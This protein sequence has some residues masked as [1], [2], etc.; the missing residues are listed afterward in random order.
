MNEWRILVVED[1]IDG[2]EVVAELLSY[3]NI[4]SDAVMTGEEA[5]KLLKSRTYNGVAIDLALPGMDGWEVLQ[6]IRSN[7]ET[8]G[9]PC[10]AMTA[11]HTS[12]VRQQALE[13][14]FDGYFP[15]PLDDSTFVR[16][17]SRVISS[18]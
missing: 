7:P 16:E 6:A 12:S 2:Q 1:E 13:A 8:A 9:L 11:F 3:S 14:G 4:Q 10:V 18:H 15:K 17:L 5:L